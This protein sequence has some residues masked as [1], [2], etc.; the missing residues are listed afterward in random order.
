MVK[1]TKDG[2]YMLSLQISSNTPFTSDVHI[3]MKG[4]Q[5]YLSAADWPLLPVIMFFIYNYYCIF[6]SGSSQYVLLY[7]TSLVIRINHINTVIR[8]ITDIHIHVLFF[9]RPS[10]TI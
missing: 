6:I 2:F 3:E 4:K 1:V 9:N 8:N 5:G 7:D 10:N